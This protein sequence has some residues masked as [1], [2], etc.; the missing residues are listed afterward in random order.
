MQE[1]LKPRVSSERI[2][3]RSHEDGGIESRLIGL[4]QP[5]YRLVLIAEPDIDQANTGV[6]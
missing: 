3:D 6:G 2:E 4:V 1:I 5:D